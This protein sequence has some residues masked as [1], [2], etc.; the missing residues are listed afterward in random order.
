M[1]MAGRTITSRAKTMYLVKL[2]YSE[3][4]HA[5]STCREGDK[6]YTVTEKWEEEGL[7]KDD[8]N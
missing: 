6:Q 4:R 7:R 3:G 1:T 5:Q 8:P 2:G